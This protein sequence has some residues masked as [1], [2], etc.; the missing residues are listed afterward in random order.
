M[1]HYALCG[2]K[3]RTKGLQYA[4]S[5]MVGNGWTKKRQQQERMLGQSPARVSL[6]S[7]PGQ[8]P[9]AI[10]PRPI[11][12]IILPSVQGAAEQTTLQSAYHVRLLGLLVPQLRPPAG[13]HPLLRGTSGRLVDR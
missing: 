8:G 11:R 9:M 1:A 6:P 13:R 12:P 10:L 4:A 3:G 5:Y 7:P 2:I